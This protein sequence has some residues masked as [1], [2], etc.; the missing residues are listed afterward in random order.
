[1]PKDSVKSRQEMIREKIRYSN[2]K[3][4]DTPKVIIAL[5]IVFSKTIKNA[6][7]RITQ[8]NSRHPYETE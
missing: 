5:K 6:R 1:M 4:V 8:R 7:R 3:P 2:P